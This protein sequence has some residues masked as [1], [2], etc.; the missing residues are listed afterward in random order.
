VSHDSVN[1][2]TQAVVAGGERLPTR[3]TDAQFD[4]YANVPDLAFSPR[5]DPK[6]YLRILYKR[7]WLV[8]GCAALATLYGL[9]QAL[10]AIPLYTAS[11]R[12]QID[13]TT[14]KVV[15]RGDV[16]AEGEDSEF[17]RTQFELIMSRGMAERVVSIAHLADNIEFFRPRSISL[18]SFAKQL[19][20]GKRP[21][22]VSGDRSNRERS[23]VGRVMGARAVRPVTGSRLVDV[24]YSDPNPG[25]A[26]QVAAAYAEAFVASN[27]DKRFQ[28]NSFAKTFLED[29]IKQLKLKLE[30]SEK[31]MLDFAEQQ[32]IVVT[33]E[34]ASIAENNLSS[35][36]AALGGLIGDRIKA[37]Q[38]WKQVADVTAVNLPQFLTNGVISG[39]RD[40]KNALVAEYQEKLETYKPNYPTMVQMSQKIAEFDRQLTTEVKTIKASLKGAY[41]AALQLENDS[42]LRIDTLR[43]EVLDLQKQMVQYGFLKREVDTTRALYDQ[44]L[45]RFKEVDIAGGVGSNN[46][47]VV[48]TPEVPGSPSTDAYRSLALY[49]ALGFGAGFAVAFGLEKLDDTVRSPE[50][51]ERASLQPTL[52]IIP[53]VSELDSIETELDDLRS[54]VSEAYR[55]LC[56]SLQFATDKGL[57]RTLLVTSAGPAE[58]KSISAFAIARH[59]ALLGMKVLLIDADLR[60]PSLHKKLK[61][62][63]AVGLSNYLTGGMTPPE[64]IQKTAIGSLAFMASGPPPPN[65]ADLLASARLHSLLSTGLE[66]FDLIV[67]DGP[68]VMGLADAPLLASAAAATVFV[69]GAGQARVGLIRGAI[70]R[71][72]MARGAVIGT[73]VTKFDPKSAGYGYGVGATYG[74]GSGYGY[75]YGYGGHAY[76][77]NAVADAPKTANL[78]RPGEG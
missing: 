19:V 72:G 67:L 13:R 69:A 37:E 31:A 41:D 24:V 43:V 65:A 3:V 51:V 47:F 27:L 2:R 7:K 50:E 38:Q 4:G 54:A 39:L 17:L 42:K 62:D 59:F 71:L 18:L 9:L 29:Q 74:Y 22:P 76:G 64:S 44:L 14:V 68:P 66:V 32:Q 78:P 61:Q 77:R 70:R 26:Q 25:I 15:D 75:G 58:G 36:N 48:D 46:V 21:P 30:T 12:L 33:T 1:D 23:A 60:N 34:K 8:L 5:F 45:Q 53:L 63:N 16:S 57:P 52:G 11:V 6:E 35:A 20:V 49:L 40:R 28:A 10:V 73:I 55:S 56:T